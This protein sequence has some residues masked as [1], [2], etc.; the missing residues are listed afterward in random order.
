MVKG[1]EEDL[2]RK[3]EKSAADPFPAS[4]SA[5]YGHQGAIRDRERM[6][7]GGGGSSSSRQQPCLPLQGLGAL[8]QVQRGCL[9]CGDPPYQGR[10]RRDQTALSPSS[11]SPSRSPPQARATWFLIPSPPAPPPPL[12]RPLP[13]CPLSVFCQSHPHRPT[14]HLQKPKPLPVP[15]QDPAVHHSITQAWGCGWLT[16]A[17]G[18]FVQLCACASQVPQFLEQLGEQCPVNPVCIY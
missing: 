16:P 12:A 11:P 13:C 10:G 9:G 8:T 15:G 17:G 2:G 1:P 18:L 7:Q 3:D 6:R 14:L 5:G 4:G